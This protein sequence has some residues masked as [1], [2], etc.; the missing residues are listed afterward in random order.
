M[1]QLSTASSVKMLSR[2]GSIG[3]NFFCTQVNLIPKETFPKKPI[4]KKIQTLVVFI[5][6][7]SHDLKYY[8][9]P[10]T[11]HYFS[12]IYFKIHVGFRCKKI[13]NDIIFTISTRGPGEDRRTRS[14]YDVLVVRTMC[15]FSGKHIIFH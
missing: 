6:F 9:L 3:A 5:A 10:V 14:V 12:E 11:T 7:V 8:T 13:K 4:K 1:L 15:G 2:K